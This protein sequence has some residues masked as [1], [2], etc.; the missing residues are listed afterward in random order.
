MGLE[1]G[2]LLRGWMEKEEGW[3]ERV[4]ERHNALVKERV[5]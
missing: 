1:E 5:P 2:E 3:L 4:Y